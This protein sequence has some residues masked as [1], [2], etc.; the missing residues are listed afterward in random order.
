MHFDEWSADQCNAFPYDTTIN[1]RFP[2]LQKE[3]NE[4]Y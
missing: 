4:K 2:C 3:L 1:L